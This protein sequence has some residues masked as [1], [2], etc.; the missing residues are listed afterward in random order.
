[1]DEDK[2]KNPT[3]KDTLDR[4]AAL[5]PEDRFIPH[6]R[7]RAFLNAGDDPRNRFVLYAGG[8]GSGKTIIGACRFLDRVFRHRSKGYILANSYEQLERVAVA[9]VVDLAAR[10]DLDPKVIRTRHMIE[11]K[12]APSEIYFHSTE[13][14]ELIRGT[15]MGFFW[16]DE[17]R[18]TRFDAW[19]VLQGRLRHRGGPLKGDLTSTPSGLGHWLYHEFASDRRRMDAAVVHGTSYD[20]PYLDDGYLDSL[21][22]AYQGE[23]FDQEVNAKFTNPCEGRCYF[24]FDRG[25]HAAH[26][27]YLRP[28]EPVHVGVDFNVSPMSAVFAHFTHGTILVFA[29]W[30][31]RNS[32]TGKLIAKIREIAGDRTPVTVYPDASGSA[33]KTAAEG[34]DHSLLVQAG[35]PVE[36]PPANPA[37]RDRV[38]AV[39]QAF[40][41]GKLEI[42]RGATELIQSLEATRWKEN[43]SEIDKSA[44]AEHLSDALGYLV[45]R[46][47]P[48]EKPKPRTKMISRHM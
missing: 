41:N 42:T 20:N 43:T 38:T 22:I 44:G 45:H 10:I 28:G 25:V 24:S 46:L 9:Q 27:L 18:G 8:V 37:Q 16:L 14:F 29:E 34:S 39:T 17:A 35:F 3:R 2:Q 5:K 33:R 7:Q 30:S 23:F 4:L 12:S 15:E 32:H 21:R 1:M 26:D 47:L 48:V 19:R 13:N 6:A 40:L 36:A 11:I 31:E